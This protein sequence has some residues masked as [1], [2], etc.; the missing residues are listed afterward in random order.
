MKLKWGLGKEEGSLPGR[1]GAGEEKRGDSCFGDLLVE[2][3]LGLFTS[4]QSEC[5]PLLTWGS[6]GPEVKREVKV[7]SSEVSHN[8]REGGKPFL[9]RPRWESRERGIR[10][11]P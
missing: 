3:D 11:T 8:P 2:L 10:V 9:S 1:R 5:S 4:L 7:S 6:V